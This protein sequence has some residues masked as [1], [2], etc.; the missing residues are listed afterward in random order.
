MTQTQHTSSSDSD[1]L[2]TFDL[3]ASAALVC[4]GFE[5]MEVDKRNPRKALFIFQRAD[6]IED[7][8]DQ[9]WSDR[10]ETKAR[11]Y[12]DTIKMLKNRLYSD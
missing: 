2:K 5:L 11:A 4:A 6:G 7:V 8:V 1:V 3:G 9:Y 10:L 12:F